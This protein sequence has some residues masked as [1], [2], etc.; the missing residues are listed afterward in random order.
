MRTN[1]FIWA[2][3]EYRRRRL[4]WI[5]AGMPIGKEPYWIERPSRSA[6]RWITHYMV[7]GYDPVTDQVRIESFK[8]TAPTDVPWWLAWTHALFVGRAQAGDWPKTQPK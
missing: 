4:E 3:N 5:K 7:G 6:P 1:C 2:R 8:P